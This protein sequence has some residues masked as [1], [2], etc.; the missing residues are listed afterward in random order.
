[1]GSAQVSHRAKIRETWYKTS[2]SLIN[3]VSTAL[4][5]IRR[6]SLRDKLVGL[7]KGINKR[8]I[9]VKLWTHN[10]RDRGREPGVEG[11]LVSPSIKGVAL[12]ELLHDR[13]S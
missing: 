2:S 7:R 5:A 1:M 13:G 3:Q 4:K 10:A 11:I 9:K 6:R 12:S 8:V